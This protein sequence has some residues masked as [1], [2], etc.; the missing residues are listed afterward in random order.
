M[1]KIIALCLCLLVVVFCFT[2]CKYLGTT[3]E[4]ELYDRFAQKHNV[5]MTKQE[6]FDKLGCPVSYVDNQGSHEINSESKEKFETN[7]FSEESV[8][9]IY[10]CDADP[11]SSGYYVLTI[12]FDSEG[13]STE[14]WLTGIN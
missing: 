5:G 4:Y 10:K 6:V 9:W 2:S 7:L 8:R 3:E 12:D 13:K 11:P 14:V 1:K